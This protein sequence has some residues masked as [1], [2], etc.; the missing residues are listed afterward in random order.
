MAQPYIGEIRM[1]AGNFA[2]AGF[3]LGQNG[4]VETVTLTVSQMPAHNH[5]LIGTINVASATDPTG[6]LVAKPDKNLYRPDGGTV[7]AMAAQS[8]SGTGG[9]QPHS[10]LQ[11]YLCINF[12]ISLYGLYPTPT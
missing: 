1:F 2:P 9:S 10:N 8:V 4:G 5:P 6:N 7:A 12:I 3:A 11:P